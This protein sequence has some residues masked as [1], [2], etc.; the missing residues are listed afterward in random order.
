MKYFMNQT[1]LY[2]GLNL[3]VSSYTTFEK[4]FSED[5]FFTGPVI[6]ISAPYWIN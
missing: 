3:K 5:V 4:N 2:Q 1:F 6:A